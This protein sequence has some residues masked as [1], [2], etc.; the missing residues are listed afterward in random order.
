ME[1]RKNL[2]AQRGRPCDP[3]PPL[4]PPMQG[5]NAQKD[6]IGADS[7]FC[8]IY[9]RNRLTDE[10]SIRIKNLKTRSQIVERI[11]LQCLFVPFARVASGDPVRVLRLFHNKYTG[12][13]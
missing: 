13:I 2:G 10:S 1:S 11:I 3:P 5:Q 4:G 6:F 8:F 12:Y 7:L 9:T